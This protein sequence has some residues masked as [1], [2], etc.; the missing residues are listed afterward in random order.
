VSV[1]TTDESLERLRA[2]ICAEGG[3]LAA[4]VAP[5]TG[6]AVFGPL[7]ALGPRTRAQAVDYD[8]VLESILE[9]YLVHYGTPRLLSAG[10][11]DLRLLAG[12]FLYALGLARLAEL[13]DL[14]AVAELG[15]LI[16]LCAQAHA[17]GRAALAPGGE[18]LPGAVWALSALAV[19]GGRWP[20]H[21]RAM[22]AARE[23]AAD[24]PARGLA[25]AAGRAEDL[26]IG[27]DLQ[28]ALI[29]FNGTFPP[30]SPTT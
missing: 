24:A 22:R 26:G 17:E 4:A 3:E 5:V 25:A 20:E 11:P 30:S 14:E 2:L 29:A 10:D 18:S 9:G 8:V 21:A 28:R 23:G 6:V 19:A 13:G 27:P 1:T 12:D 15:D 7:A 16:T